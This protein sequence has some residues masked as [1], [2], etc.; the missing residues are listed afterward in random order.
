MAAFAGPM[1]RIRSSPPLSLSQ[2]GPADAVGQSR[3]CGAGLGSVR[4]VRTGRA[5]YDRA[6][7]GSFLWMG[8][9]AVPLRRRSTRSRRRATAGAADC[10]VAP[11]VRLS[12]RAVGAA[13]P[14]L[15]AD[16]VRSDVS[17]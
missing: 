14:S 2:R 12:L 9:D 7:F 15:M 16:R 3:G 13:R 1:V 5:G 6:L 11:D 8:I 17:R 10:D 4:D